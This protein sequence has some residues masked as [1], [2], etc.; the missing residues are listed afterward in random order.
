TL[1]T[2]RMLL[3]ATPPP[4]APPSFPTRR[5]S[6]LDAAG[7]LPSRASR[8]YAAHHRL[9][10]QRLRAGDS[11]RRQGQRPPPDHRARGRA[12]PLRASPRVDAC[13]RAGALRRRGVARRDAGLARPPSLPLPRFGG[14]EPGVRGFF[15]SCGPVSPEMDCEM[16]CIARAR[17][18]PRLPPHQKWIAEWIALRARTTHTHPQEAPLTPG[19]SPQRG[20]GRKTGAHVLTVTSGR[21]PSTPSRRISRSTLR[22]PLTAIRRPLEIQ[23]GLRVYRFTTSLD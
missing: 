13:R 11:D 22:C 18:H 5:S 12:G 16:D 17:T 3:S 7:R 20:E 10:D 4:P 8:R 23:S 21:L 9:L 14:E 19:P 1:L 15:L 6:D 2:L